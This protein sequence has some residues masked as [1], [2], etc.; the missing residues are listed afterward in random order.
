MTHMLVFC[1]WFKLYVWIIFNVNCIVHTKLLMRFV[2]DFQ[3]LRPLIID[4]VKQT[5]FYLLNFMKEANL[6][7]KGAL[8]KKF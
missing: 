1:V 2:D 4:C 5:T 7:G 3:A 6:V 8:R